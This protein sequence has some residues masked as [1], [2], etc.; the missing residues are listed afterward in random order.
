MIKSIIEEALNSPQ[1]SA[2]LAIMLLSPQRSFSAGE[3]AKRSGVSPQKLPEVMA[4]FIKLSLVNRF[5]K[6][7]SV[8]YILNRKHKQ[9]PEIVEAAHKTLPKYEDELS[10]AVGKLGEVKGA[11]LTGVFTGQTQSPVDIL[12]V[13]KVNLTKLDNFLKACTKMMGVEI[14]YSIMSQDEFLLR[15]DTFDRFLKDIFD[16][17]HLVLRDVAVTNKKLKDKTKGKK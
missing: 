1:R 16:Y 3:L 15:K 12:L 13:G 14:N 17:P 4:E 2:V 8:F 11:F 5:S 7:K 6:S 10:V 9:L